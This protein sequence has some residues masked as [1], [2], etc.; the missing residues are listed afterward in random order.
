[1]TGPDLEALRKSAG[2]TRP[3]LAKALN[4]SE[5]TIYRSERLTRGHVTEAKSQRWQEAID[6]LS[7]WDT[8]TGMYKTEADAERAWEAKLA[9]EGIPTPPEAPT[10]Q[11][12]AETAPS[13]GVTETPE[14]SV[15]D[16]V[17]GVPPQPVLSVWGKDQLRRAKL[18]LGPR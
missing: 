16:P 10:A 7:G 1:M 17:H 4:V 14:A 13:G 18:G 5:F 15:D 8:E 6:A 3:A 11:I 9:L 12:E 2:I